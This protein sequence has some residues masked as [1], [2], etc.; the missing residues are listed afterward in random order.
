MPLGDLSGMNSDIKTFRRFVLAVISILFLGLATSS[1]AQG[2]IKVVNSLYRVQLHGI[3]VNDW[4]EQ[5][6]LYPRSDRVWHTST[7][8][9]TSGFDTA[10]RGIRFKGV[11]FEGEMPP[12]MPR[13]AFQF[14]PVGRVKA[15]AVNRQSTTLKFN[16]VPACGGE[17][18]ECTGDEP[19]GVKTTRRNCRRPNAVLPFAFDYDEKVKESMTFSFGFHRSNYDFCGKK[20]PFPDSVDELPK[21]LKVG[22]G[23]KRIENLKRGRTQ[24]WKFSRERGERQDE[25][26]DWQPVTT[27]TCPPM[28]GVGIHRCWTTDLTLTIT[29]VK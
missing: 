11:S 10:G 13:P 3:Y 2:Q 12:G 1:I 22:E 29:R 20:Y 23:M 15:K 21:T 16:Q 6:E 8:N 27:K 17:L 26:T 14:L 5:S 25:S 4:H 28:S 24:I 7:G 9:I 19:K 18:G